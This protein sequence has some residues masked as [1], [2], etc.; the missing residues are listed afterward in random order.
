MAGYI[1]E[2]FAVS[3]SHTCG[4]LSLAR[5]SMYYRPVPK[6]DV[7][8]RDALREKARERKR[9]GYRRL[10]VLLRR[11]GWLDNHKRIE[12]IY[13]EERLQ[14]P[15]RKKR[16]TAY[17]RKEK[18]SA[19]VRMNERW[20]MDFVHDATAQGRKIRMLNIVDDFTREC[21]WIETDTSLNGGRVT[22]V[23]SCLVDLRGKP[24]RL[25][26][27]NGPEF[28]GH[29][30]DQWAY[31]NDVPLDFIDP[32]KPQQNGYVE[33]FNGK[34]RDECLNEHWFGNVT[35]AQEIIEDWRV[36]YNQT[37]PHSS[38]NYLA[39]A[40]FAASLPLG[41]EDRDALHPK[42]INLTQQDSH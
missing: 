22:R 30:L 8:L 24:G 36:D 39:P 14:V 28:R 1:H 31:E 4:L 18:P 37:R 27:D 11:D 3:R 6:N 29:V 13:R 34:F 7:P 26:M 20:S 5:S 17:K 33:S 32:G 40:E 9:W 10:I 35:E 12:R 21:L 42:K 38:L 41:G 16:K 23:L 2:S 25:V 15:K 19:P